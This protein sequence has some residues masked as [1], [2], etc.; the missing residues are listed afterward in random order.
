MTEPYGMDAPND[1]LIPT[2]PVGKNR[3]APFVTDRCEGMVF[4]RVLDFSQPPQ[5]CFAF[6][7]RLLTPPV[8][9]WTLQLFCSL[10]LVARC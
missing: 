10:L 1:P 5:P 6:V 4:R 2:L 3:Y 9:V 8:K 7:I